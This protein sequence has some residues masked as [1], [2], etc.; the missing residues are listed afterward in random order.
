[1]SGASAKYKNKGTI[2]EVDEVAV[3]VKDARTWNGKTT[4]GPYSLRAADASAD[5]EKRHRSKRR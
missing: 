1:M 2:K 4:S 5:R 3:S